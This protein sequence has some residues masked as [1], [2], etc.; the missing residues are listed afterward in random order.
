MF[1][2]NVWNDSNSAV[3]SVSSFHFSGLGLS[4]TRRVSRLP[5]SAASAKMFDTPLCSV[6]AGQI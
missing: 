6:L 1:D 4:S 5:P 2:S 3:F